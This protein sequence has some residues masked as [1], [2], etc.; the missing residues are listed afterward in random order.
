MSNRLLSQPRAAL[1]S[2]ALT[3]STA[4]APV[5]ATPACAQS[6]A[7]AVHRFDIK[8]QALVDAMREFSRATGI[9]VAYTASIGSGIA[10][11]GVSGS[12]APAEA[13]SRLLTGTGLTFRFTGP[14]AV[15]LEPAPRSDGDAVQL[16]P[17]RVEGSGDDGT[18][19]RYDY[20]VETAASPVPS[21]VA[22][23]SA[24]GTKTDT[25]IIETPQSISI[26]TREALDNQ[27]A[28]NLTEALRYTAGVSTAAYLNGSGDNY[29]IFTIRGFANSNSGL[30]RDGMRLNY[31]V[32][33]A[34]TE[35]YGLERVEVLKGPS[36]TIYGQSGPSGV[37][38]L[39]SKR[40][41]TTPLHEVE[42]QAGTFDR[43]QIATDHGGRLDADGKFSYRLTGLL[44]DSNE[45]TDYGRNDRIYVAPA[46]SWRPTDRTEL[47]VLG[48]YQKSKTSY[49]TG[50]P[51]S[52]TVLPN[53]NETIERDRYLGDPSFNYWDTKAFYAGYLFEHR[54]SDAIKL[55]SGLR[56]SE[57][58]L[59][60]GYLYP[61]ALQADGRTMT[62]GAIRRHDDS[63]NLSADNNVQARW[64]AAGGEH[65]TM[66]GIDYGL[67]HYQRTRWFA[68]APSIDVY[69][70][71]Y[72]NIGSLSF[73]AP[74][75]DSPIRYEQTGIY[76]QQQSKFADRIVLTLNGRQ[77]WSDTVVTN[78]ATGAKT[79]TEADAFT[80][81]T[82]LTYVHPSG[83]APYVSYSESFEP[84]TG[85]YWDGSPFVP[86]TGRQFEA[87]VKYQPEGSDTLVTLAAYHMKQR[88]VSTPDP[89]Q[90]NHP[91]GQVQTGEIRSKGIELEAQSD[92]TRN[93]RIRGAFTLIDAEVTK[94]NIAAQIGLVP[95]DTPS[96]MASLWADYTVREGQLSGLSFGLGGRYTS[97]AYD[98]TN[99]VK[100]D[101]RTLFDTLVAYQVDH[102]RL[103]INATNIFDKTYLNSCYSTCWYG[104]PRSVDV[105]VRLSW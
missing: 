69:N 88:N 77:D 30:L 86:T 75:I 61:D 43:Y 40:P 3:L 33:D 55:K 6:T 34:P 91:G 76:I 78:L 83:F 52:G 80:F 64:T 104:R 14:N 84:S 82:G 50:L 46:V 35:T 73:A 56:Y 54:F 1:L 60:Y 24:V 53:P 31:N 70:P 65:V 98:I 5:I 94:S 16:G 17:V 8:P 11:P 85:S 15:T 72:R 25:P 81:R 10:S 101:G 28:V 2:T 99:S 97:G 45:W 13:L 41:T 58:K 32:F 36:G 95:V 67:S 37:V 92:I 49:Y 57:S 23:R 68:A 20:S 79:R 74:R 29:D 102:W 93:L 71:S 51:Y 48:Y 42:V 12:L 63:D 26:V 62:R 9:Q 100:T 87:G 66:V 38:N 22:R 4:L 19:A 39:V 44:R 96:T 27:G 47:T 90:V 103:A 59:D 18:A 89:D 105:S 21:Y 7:P